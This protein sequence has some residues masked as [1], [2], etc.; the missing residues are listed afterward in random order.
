MKWDELS[1]IDRAKYIQLGVYNGITS[2]DNI[3]SAYNSYAEGGYKDWI[4]KVKEWRPGIEYDIDSDTIQIGINPLSIKYLKSL[5]GNLEEDAGYKLNE[6]SWGGDLKKALKRAKKSANDIVSKA[7]SKVSSGIDNIIDDINSLEFM[8]KYHKHK[9]E[10]EYKKKLSKLKHQFIE[11]DD[12]IYRVNS[13]LTKT[14]VDVT[15]KGYEWTTP[16]GKRMRFKNTNRY[17]TLGENKEA[18]LE[19][20]N[21]GKEASKERLSSIKNMNTEE[22]RDVQFTLAEEG[23]YTQLLKSKSKNEIKKIQ[24]N[25]G[26]KVDGIV[27]PLTESAFV[28]SQV[29]GKYGKNTEEALHIKYNNNSNRVE[30]GLDGCAQFVT[31]SYEANNGEV[32]QQNGV[33]GDA[34]T[35]PYNIVNKGG[36]MKYNLYDDKDF[37][38]IKDVDTLKRTTIKKA[39]EH[40]L[41]YNNVE[42]GDIVG[43]FMPS[44]DMHKVALDNGTTKNTHVG[45]VVGFD[46]DGTPLVRHNIHTSYRTDR[47]DK[48]TGSKSGNPFITVV[49]SPKTSS[50]DIPELHFEPKKSTIKVDGKV[51]KD[52]NKVMDGMEGAVNIF[53]KMFKNI[54]VYDAMEAA[55]AVQQRETNMGNNRASDIAEREGRFSKNNISNALRNAYRDYKGLDETTKSSNQMKMKLSS[56]LPYEQKMLGVNSAKDL[57]NPYKAGVAALYIM[58]KNMDYFNRLAATYPEL[59]I[60]KDDIE[61]L[62]MLSYNQG[63]GKLSSIGFNDSG[64]YAPSELENIRHLADEN[65]RIK[66]ISST[67]YRYFGKVGNW[68]YDNFGSSFVPYIASAKKAKRKLHRS[69]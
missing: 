53:Q 34:W 10:E 20:Y 2:L 54:D 59:E 32:S 9:E 21:L 11:E 25:L 15:D 39:K 61:S 51:G 57:E 33:I 58:C 66:D 17:E 1:M 60:N 26:L 28:A 31:A 56:L 45:Y 19:A 5:G 52:F 36:K 49:A 35:M 14:K 29:D 40:K 46:K 69:S 37:D 24:K 13:D 48:L 6:Y 27:G 18:I 44:S 50:L 3:R 8:Q 47:A 65:T 42:L 30:E 23:Y 38:N 67:N 68:M 64:I 41:D 55:L 43:I 63:M 16:E 7:E 62:T 12:T 22:L 4:Q